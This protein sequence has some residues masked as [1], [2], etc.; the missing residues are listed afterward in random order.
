MD[1]SVF[2]LD[3]FALMAHFGGE[4]GGKQV[5]DLLEKAEAGEVTLVM[6]LINVGELVYLMSRARGRSAAE[7]ML[8]DLKNLPIL[9]FDATE[10]RILSAAWVKSEY[11]VSYADSFAISLAKEFNATLVSG[12]PEFHAL[13][14]TIPILWLEQ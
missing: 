10:E 8:E 11:P 3:S 6:S 14:K 5:L 12:E 1:S 7:S 13:E 2:V 9:F 4:T